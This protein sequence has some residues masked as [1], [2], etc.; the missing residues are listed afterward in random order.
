MMGDG[1]HFMKSLLRTNDP[2]HV[3]AAKGIEGI[4]SLLEGWRVVHVHSAVRF[5]EYKKNKA[6][7]RDFLMKKR[8]LKRIKSGQSSIQISCS[9]VVLTSGQKFTKREHL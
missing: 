2:K 6:F 3:K 7:L 9:T 5:I 8:G 1:C 4:K